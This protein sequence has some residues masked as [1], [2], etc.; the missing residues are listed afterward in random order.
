[1]WSKHWKNLSLESGS[2]DA[3]NT[4]NL[5]VCLVCDVTT[6]RYGCPV[7]VVGGEKPK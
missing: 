6:Q 2:Y 4:G 7:T 5:G 1:M 3:M